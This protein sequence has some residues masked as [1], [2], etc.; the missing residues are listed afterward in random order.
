MWESFADWLEQLVRRY[1]LVR[2]LGVL[3]GI[4]AILAAVGVSASEAT[5]LGVAVIVLIAILLVTVMAQYIDRVKLYSDR[6]LAA[7]VLDRYAVELRDRQNEHSFETMIWR[8]IQ[9]VSENGDTVIER[10]LTLRVGSEPLQ[11]L[12]QRC[13]QENSRGAD[14]GYQRKVRVEARSFEETGELGVQLPITQTWEG[15]SI[16]LFVHFFEAQAPGSEVR[17][18][19]RLRWPGYM[20]EFAKRG[21]VVPIEWTTRRITGHLALRLEL[22]VRMAGARVAATPYAGCPQPTQDRVGDSHVVTFNMP[23]PPVDRLVGFR[24]ERV[25]K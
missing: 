8:E 20:A 6:R 5:V 11:T 16:R 1:G 18:W 25:L 3:G 7:D 9:V 4:A 13:Y 21:A 22:P 12:W 23:G 24:I 10:W 14:F 2:I 17:I 19:L 15:H